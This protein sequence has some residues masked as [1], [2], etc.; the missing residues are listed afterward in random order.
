MAEAVLGILV[1][2]KSG[3]WRALARSP[4]QGLVC[5]HGG[6]LVLGWGCSTRE[7]VLSGW[8]AVE[9]GTQKDV[10]STPN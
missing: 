8:G 2:A 5:V 9:K 6:E 4:W 10:F 7:G 1:L 3:R